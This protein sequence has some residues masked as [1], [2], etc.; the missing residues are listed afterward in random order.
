[1][2]TAYDSWMLNLLVHHLTSRLL[3]VK[4]EPCYSLIIIVVGLGI[5]IMFFISLW[6]LTQL[7]LMLCFLF[8]CLLVMAFLLSSFVA[9][10]SL[11]LVCLFNSPLGCRVSKY[12]N[13]NWFQL[14]LRFLLLVNIAFEI[15][16][17]TFLNYEQFRRR[18]ISVSLVSIVRA[19][20]LELGF[21]SHENQGFSFPPYRPD[22]PGAHP[23]SVLVPRN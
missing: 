17:P 5:I 15:I 7:I 8:F 4:V 6:L 1:M 3:K 9:L 23:I 10:L 11:Y 20:G 2:S 21:D 12:T 13:E 19:R 14:W 18:G 16:S 22:S